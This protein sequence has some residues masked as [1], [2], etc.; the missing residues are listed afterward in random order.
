MTVARGVSPAAAAAV[1]SKSPPSPSRARVARPLSEEGSTGRCSRWPD[2]WCGR[3]FLFFVL[4]FFFAVAAGSPDD[5]VGIDD[6]PFE[7]GRAPL[8]RS[9]LTAAAVTCADA[10]A[11]AAERGIQGSSEAGRAPGEDEESSPALG[12][13]GKLARELIAKTISA[14]SATEAPPAAAPVTNDE[15]CRCLEACAGDRG[16]GLDFEGLCGAIIFADERRPLFDEKRQG[17]GKVYRRHREP[18]R[19]ALSFL[20]ERFFL[21]PRFSIF[22]PTTMQSLSSARVGACRPAA[23]R[24]VAAPAPSP[25][26][27][28]HKMTTGTTVTRAL[29]PEQGCVSIFLSRF[30]EPERRPRSFFESRRRRVAI[31]PILERERGKRWL[32]N[33]S[34]V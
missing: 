15:R 3:L 18:D 33:L 1:A 22:S 28:T 32:A 4:P 24:S 16:G 23:L 7:A 21:L 6:D 9:A 19:G 25:L 34:N 5:D 17:S 12:G 20:L 10:D 27:Q 11:W 30:F 14:R 2:C 31:E 29:T 8:S 26:K 13:G